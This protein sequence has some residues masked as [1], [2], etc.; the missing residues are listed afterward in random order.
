MAI[1]GLQHRGEA[2]PIIGKIRKGDR[3]GKNGAP[4]DLDYFRV[5]FSEGEQDAEALFRAAYGDKPREINI[6][7]PFDELDRCW[8][9]WYEAYTASKMVARGDGEFFQYR[10]SLASGEILVKDWKNA[11]TGLPAPQVEIVGKAGKSEIK[12]KPRGRLRVIVPEIGKF[13]YLQL[14]TGSIIDI[15]N[16]QDNLDGIRMVTGGRLVGIPM[17][18]KR[19]KISVSIPDIG[20]KDMWCLQIEANTRWATPM[21]KYMENVSLPALQ[22]GTEKPIDLTLRE[23]AAL[24]YVESEDEYED[25]NPLAEAEDYIDAAAIETGEDTQE[26]QPQEAAEQPQE[27]QEPQ[28]QQEPTQ[29]DNDPRY[30]SAQALR[31]RILKVAENMQGREISNGARGLIVSTLEEALFGTGDPQQNRYAVLKYLTGYT[32][33]TDMPDHLASALFGWL[34]PRKDSGGAWKCSEQAAAEAVMVLNA[35]MP[36]QEKLF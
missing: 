9:A 32:H 4:K 24:A 29:V 25:E 26:E 11:Q 36:E 21:F 27:A 17:I 33:T 23:A 34:Q 10:V 5:V 6:F 2:F 3:S 12:M 31:S 28:E 35:A 7:L 16:I 22:S 19:R 14:T 18:L 1:K 30:A 8:E 15:R 20:R 13:A